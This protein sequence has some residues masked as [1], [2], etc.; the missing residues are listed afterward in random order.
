MAI[1]TGSTKLLGGTEKETPKQ[2]F[3]YGLVEKNVLVT[4][5][6]GQ[7]G[8]ELKALSER[9]NLPFRFIFTDV[10]DLDVTKR[11]EVIRFVNDNHIHY[12]IHCAAYTAVDRAETDA[13]TAFLLNEKAVENVALAAL[14]VGAKVI[15]VSTDFVFDGEARA[16]YKEID[17]PRPISVYGKSKLKGEQAL[18]AVGGEW[19]ILRTSWLYSS[20]GNNFVKTMLRLMN[21]KDQLTIVDDQ[22]G[23]PTYA[24]DLAE[25]I[26]HILQSTEQEEWKNG[27]YH[28]SNK[29]ETTWFDF[30][31]KIKQLAGIEGC[32]LLPVKSAEYGAPA[33]RP[34]YSVMDLSNICATFHV[35]IPQWE[36]ALDRCIRKLISKSEK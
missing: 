7:L 27:I 1:Y 2:M 3:F 32:E 22:K 28:F 19:I 21:E 35:E 33:L 15:H 5:A 31:R 11:E 16:P 25:M 26:V 24:A 6:N 8:S 34:A 9:L 18:Q 10:S 4:G 12:I 30:A 36:E 23:A 17:V 20:F 13:D 29:G 14:E